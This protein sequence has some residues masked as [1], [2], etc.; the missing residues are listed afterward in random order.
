M[1][2]KV[3]IANVSRK[4]GM[5]GRSLCNGN[6]IRELVRASH[7]LSSSTKVDGRVDCGAPMVTSCISVCIRSTLVLLALAIH[8]L[9]ACLTSSCICHWVDWVLLRVV[10]CYVSHDT[11]HG[12]CFSSIIGRAL[13]SVM[14]RLVMSFETGDR[15][16]VACFSSVV[17][18]GRV[19]A[20][21]GLTCR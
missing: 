3:S 1:V 7:N 16:P 9:A 5:S 18:R 17:L 6:D 2:S 13:S 11:I 20:G 8:S 19:W 15:R 21:S 10:T 4:R 12:R 14:A